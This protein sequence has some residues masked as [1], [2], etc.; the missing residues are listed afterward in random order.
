[1]KAKFS[2][3]LE[4]LSGHRLLTPTALCS[5]LSYRTPHSPCLCLFFLPH[6]NGRHILSNTHPAHNWF[7]TVCF[8]FLNKVTK[9]LQ[10]VSMTEHR[11][12]W[13]F[14]EVSGSLRLRFRPVWSGTRCCARVCDFPLLW[15]P[16]SGLLLVGQPYAF[17]WG[18][19]DNWHSPV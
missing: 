6:I 17:L 7:P 16:Q 19:A 12:S 9:T 3:V 11:S 13:K 15:P 4:N 14:R 1:M 8:F 5:H 10:W 18:S 2:M